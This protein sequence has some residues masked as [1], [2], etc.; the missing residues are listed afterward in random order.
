MERAARGGS[1]RVV[2]LI[3]A[4]A[5]IMLAALLVADVAAPSIFNG[6]R[7]ITPTPRVVGNQTAP[8]HGGHRSHNAPKPSGTGPVLTALSPESAT[9]GST[10][11]LVGSGFFSA[12]HAI[13]ARVAG[14]PAPTRCPTEQRCYVVLPAAPKGVT[15][16]SV[17]IV[18]ETGTSNSLTIHYG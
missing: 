8:S 12:D 7:N 10:I 15:E 11:E 17:Q 16:T 3:L 9:P 14:S 1:A 13:V 5:L 18:T 2:A 6:L 4:G